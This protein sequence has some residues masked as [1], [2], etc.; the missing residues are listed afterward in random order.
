MIEYPPG[1]DPDF[2]EPDPG[3]QSHRFALGNTSRSSAGAPPL[4]AIGMNPSHAR[5]AQADRTVN[6]L[7][8]ASVRHGYAGWV[9][10]N[11]YPERSPK[12][13]QLSAF[14]AALS[15]LNCAAIEQVLLRYGATEVLGA[16]GNMPHRTLKRAKTDVVALLDQMGVRLFTWDPLTNKGN[17]RHPSPPGRPLAMLGPKQYLI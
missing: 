9:M 13:S 15:A 5:E 6:R 8:E 16:W 14:D 2:W 7:I 17:P 11:L 10:L 12:P 3:V 4:I 1:H